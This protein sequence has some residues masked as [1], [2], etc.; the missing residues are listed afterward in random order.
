MPCLFRVLPALARRDPLTFLLTLTMSHQKGAFPLLLRPYVR[1]LST[2]ARVPDL[3]G[4]ALKPSSQATYGAGGLARAGQA[5]HTV[6]PR[7]I[8]LC[9]NP[10]FLCLICRKLSLGGVD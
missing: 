10:F 8:S 4:P 3:K 6:A 1:T 2:R 7:R 9:G 5:T